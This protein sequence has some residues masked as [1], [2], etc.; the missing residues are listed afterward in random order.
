MTLYEFLAT[1]TPLTLSQLGLS[2]EKTTNWLMPNDGATH[3][4]IGQ[5]V[6]NTRRSYRDS[7][8]VWSIWQ[9]GVIEYGWHSGA[10]WYAVT[11][12]KQTGSA[13]AR[14]K[15]S[16]KAKVAPKDVKVSPRAV[17][18]CQVSYAKLAKLYDA[19]Y[20]AY[21]TWLDGSGNAETDAKLYAAYEKLASRYDIAEAKHSRIHLQPIYDA[22]NKKE[23]N[24]G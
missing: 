13:I 19:A 18:R 20:L 7:Y 23:H 24:N 11:Y 21:Q 2:K 4:K 1:N 17:A 8:A 10:N 14:V 15:V 3:A 9:N 6:N 16:P 12:V 5:I 22:R